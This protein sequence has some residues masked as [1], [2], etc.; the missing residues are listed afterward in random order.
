MKSKE[1]KWREE[2]ANLSMKAMASVEMNRENNI[3]WP[4]G[5]KTII[6]AQ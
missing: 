3:L 1:M 4:L 2:M 6:M 5:V